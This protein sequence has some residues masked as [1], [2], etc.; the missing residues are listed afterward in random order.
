MIPKK[1][2][3][4]VKTG[5]EYLSSPEKRCLDLAVACLLIGP[6]ALPMAGVAVSSAIDTRTREPLI[7]Q[8]RRGIAG[9]EFKILKFRTMRE[10]LTKDEI[11]TYGTFDSRATA[12][13]Q[14]LRQY[15]IDEIPQFLNVIKGDMSI[16]GPRPL[17]ALDMLD[18]SK[19][20]EIGL[21][22]GIWVEWLSAYNACKPGITGRGQLDRHRHRKVPDEVLLE[23]MIAD[24][25]YTEKASLV[26]DL[27]II[28]STPV[29][30]F[31]INRALSNSD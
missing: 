3:K 18:R 4:L 2:T 8:A 19:R 5:L 11:E 16:V 13:G 21:R 28:A 20:K 27:G 26:V 7:R 1:S 14:V 10:S 30:L 17:L 25:E 6:L 29:E 22:E 12:L 23:S 31:L 24:I 15:G 9:S